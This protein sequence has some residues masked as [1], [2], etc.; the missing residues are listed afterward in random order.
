MSNAPVDVLTTNNSQAIYD[1]VT[2]LNERC[3]RQ[4]GFMASVRHLSTTIER[5]LAYRAALDAHSIQPNET[6]IRYLESMTDP[7]QASAD[8]LVERGCTA[9]VAS[10]NVLTSKLLAALYSGA[11]ADRDVEI[12]GYRDPAHGAYPHDGAQWLEEPIGEMGRLAAEAILRRI[13]DPL[14]EPVAT[15]LRASYTPQGTA[16]FPRQ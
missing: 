16:A 10:N 5:V 15:V 2:A 9:I 11:W 4:I 1:G 7:V 13:A 3:H 14:A 8:A 6:L 12:L